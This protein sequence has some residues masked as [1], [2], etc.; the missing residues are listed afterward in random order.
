M[1]SAITRQTR[2]MH[3]QRTLALMQ[4]IA[5]QNSAERVRM[6]FL[7][8]KSR[9]ET[10]SADRQRRDFK[11]QRLYNDTPDKKAALS[12]KFIII[13]GKATVAAVATNYLAAKFFLDG[14]EIFTLGSY[15]T[16]GS[17]LACLA[18]VKIANFHDRYKANKPRVGN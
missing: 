13:N 8:R 1:I 15:I 18:G 10:Y 6:F 17:P 16:I 12:Q 14:T 3:A 11:V 9:P 5:S 7:E 4:N 2:K